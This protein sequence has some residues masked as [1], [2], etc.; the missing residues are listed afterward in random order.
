MY[1][2]EEQTHSEFLRRGGMEGRRKV[3]VLEVTET[4]RR[5]K[6]KD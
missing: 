3:R 1:M 5:L 6:P 4:A 2:H